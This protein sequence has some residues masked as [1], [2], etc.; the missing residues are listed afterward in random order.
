MMGL[1]VRI[2]DRT[3][4]LPQG[5]HEATIEHV[6]AAHTSETVGDLLTALLG[7]DPAQHAHPSAL[8]LMAE[9]VAFLTE[10]APM[11]PVTVP[12]DVPQRSWEDW[13]AATAALNTSDPQ[14][15]AAP[16]VVKVYTG[17][18]DWPILDLLA[19]WSH[20]I[21]QMDAHIERFA[22]LFNQR[23]DE[24]ETAAGIDK[25]QAF[26]WFGTLDALAGGDPLRYDPILQTP[27]ITIHTKLLLDMVKN[28]YLRKLN[29]Y[30]EI[31]AGRSVNAGGE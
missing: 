12:V 15:L 23:P 1:T 5:W 17:R 7:V 21:E 14:I 30:H 27:V 13:N 6:A 2:N 31:S 3:V 29:R 24:N 10:P 16:E 9:A 11:P 20:I 26:G 25:I 18:T 28:E 19:H 8:V 22:D 4:T